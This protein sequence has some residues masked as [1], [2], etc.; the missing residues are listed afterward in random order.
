MATESDANRKIHPGDYDV[1]TQREIEDNLF[2]D[3][4]RHFAA[5]NLPLALESLN[6]LL[7]ITGIKAFVYSLKVDLLMQ[8][9]RQ[10]D[11]LEAANEGI[12]YNNAP[13]QL[14]KLHAQ[15][16]ASFAASR[17]DLQIALSSIE[18]A[19]SLYNSDAISEDI[20]SQ[21]NSADTFKFWVENKT[22]TRDEM[23]SL[24]ADIKS[25]LN[26]LEVYEKVQQIE[27][28]INQEKVKTIELM[29]IFT[30]ILAL[31]F[32]NVQ[33]MQKLQSWEIVVANLSLLIAIT[34][35][36][37]LV[38]RISLRDTFLPQIN[39]ERAGRFIGAVIVVCFTALLIMG[40][41][42]TG[43][44]FYKWIVDLF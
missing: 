43:V 36:L 4:Q 15:L 29:A 17:A 24:R 32:A 16:L 27:A 38:H 5:N 7:K 33:F 11:A 41:V 12:Q 19:I 39:S 34:W 6:K 18:T 44:N 22:R 21:F 2:K 10:R 25:L 8:M 35:L 9:N 26:T 14:Y 1:T 20:S 23:T 31:I 42:F 3:Y 37:Y 30:A 28:N 13:S 40:L